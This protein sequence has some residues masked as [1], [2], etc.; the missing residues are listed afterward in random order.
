MAF[1][2]LIRPEDVEFRACH[3]EQKTVLLSIDVESDFGTGKSSA[4]SQLGRLLDLLDELGIPLTAFVEGQLFVTRPDLCRLLYGHGVDVQL[5]CHDHGTDG[6][7]PELLARGVAAYA[8]Y[9]GI[10]PNGYRAHTYRL[11]LELYRA[12]IDNGIKWDSSILPALAQ[13]GN[14]N[15]QFRTGD[16]LRF[17]Q[18]LIEFPIATWAKFPL[19]LN[20]SYRLLMGRPVESLLRRFLGPRNLVA[21]NMHMVDLVYCQSL[22]KAN[23]PTLVKLLYRYMWGFN[24][25]DTFASLRNII[26][27]LDA[28]GYEFR[29][30]DELYRSIGPQI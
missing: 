6:D 15:R 27:Y 11:G 21:Y 16:Y 12:L 18:G 29:H 2:G 25:Q 17:E 3:L 14:P 13:G 9:C 22:G 10:M 28:M 23:L 19:P 30:T 4:L 8:D 1:G 26:T 7:T 20:H 24:R 5:H